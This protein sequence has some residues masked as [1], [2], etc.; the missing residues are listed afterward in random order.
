MFTF[1]F[2]LISLIHISVSKTLQS[3][4]VIVNTPYTIEDGNFLLLE[5]HN[6]SIEINEYL[7]FY[8]TKKIPLCK[9]DIL[10]I[11]NHSIYIFFIIISDTAI[12][13]ANDQTNDSYTC[14]YVIGSHKGYYPIAP[15]KNP[16][17]CGHYNILQFTNKPITFNS[18]WW[19]NSKD[20]Y[21]YLQN[22]KISN[23][24]LYQF[25]DEICFVYI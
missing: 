22:S 11:I 13:C 2:L 4:H 20:F 7:A 19:E 17:I 23:I 18:F 3:Q 24:R 5:V 14:G 10:K 9:Y 15:F 21:R 1:H 16:L 6:N 25:L 12:Q 8:S